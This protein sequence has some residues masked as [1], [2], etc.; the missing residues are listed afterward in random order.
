MNAHPPVHI[1]ILNYKGWRDTLEC[2]ESVLELDYPN[3]QVL[4]AD[5][6]SPDESWARLEAWRRDDPSIRRFVVDD[7]TLAAPAPSG[8][9]FTFLKLAENRGF[10]GGNNAALRRLLALG[11]DGYVWLLNNDTVVERSALRELVGVAES[12]PRVGAVGGTMLDFRTPDVLQFAAG[13]EISAW[14]GMTR[15]AAPG[16]PRSTTATLNPR[17]NFICG[18]CLLIPMA[19]LREV[20][21]FDERFFM[22]AED[23]DLC[24]RIA[25]AGGSLA[26]SPRAEIRHK[27]GATAIPKSP[28]SDFHNL[29]SSLLF[30][31]KHR[32]LRF[33]ASLVYSAYRCVLPKIVRRDWHRL[34]AVFRAYRDVFAT[35]RR[36][37]AT[38]RSVV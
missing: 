7:A 35:I 14:T 9:N 32:P 37:R 8:T 25:E 5:N 29:R 38:E 12:T 2:L 34:P 18:G 16:A 1:V 20:G 13:G 24:R 30:V 19:M 36:Q 15:N 21:V 27:G 3:I 10:T 23:A 6:A 11:A 4:V 28:V 26:Y 17:L 22:Y 33:P 31:Q